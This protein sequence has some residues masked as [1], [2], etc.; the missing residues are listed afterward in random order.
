MDRNPTVSLVM[1]V[2]N[3]ERYLREAVD[4]ILAQTFTDFELIIIDDG[5]TDDSAGIVRRY[6][7][8]RIRFLQN[9]HNLGL[10]ATQN[11][12]IAAARGK[13]IAVMDCDDRSYP[14]RLERQVDFLES[15]PSV[16]MCGTFRDNCVDGELKSFP[17]PEL[18]TDAEIKFSLVFGN[19]CYTHSS[20]MF[21]AEPYREAGLSYGP[22]AIAEDYQ[23][24]LEMAKR[25]SLAVIPEVLVSYRIYGESTSQQRL[26]EITEAAVRI[27][28]DYLQTIAIS[29]ESRKL[30]MDYFQ[31]G[32][33]VEG[34]PAFERALQELAD[35][36]Q[37]ELAENPAA[38]AFALEQTRQYILSTKQYSGKLWRDIRS[39]RFAK[40]LRRDKVFWGKVFGACILHYKPR[41]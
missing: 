35:L 29:R 9:E 41:G 27:K 3:G 16:M 2:Y 5:S 40:A 1:K 11:K 7:D 23:I 39:S 26:Q 4:S 19:F 25:F 10:C 22:A 33:A 24:I 12:V 38:A 6:Q 8:A 34:L 17:Q 32:M 14:K 28:C 30:L 36:Y 20:I 21:R 13:Y 31:T 37:I 18:T 15:H